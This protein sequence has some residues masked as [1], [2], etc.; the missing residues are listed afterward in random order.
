[1]KYLRNGAY[2][3]LKK[4]GR[5][6]ALLKRIFGKK[7]NRMDA[8]FADEQTHHAETCICNDD[9]RTTVKNPAH[10]ETGEVN[11]YCSKKCNQITE[12]AEGTPNHSHEIE[13]DQAVEATC[14]E[15]GMTAGSHCKRCGAIIEA[16]K[17]IPALGHE[18]EADQAVEA[19]CTDTGLTAG[20]RCKRCGAI[21]EVQKEIPVLGHEIEADQ[22]VE[23]TCTEAGMTAGSHCKRCGAVIEARKEI[24]AL[25]HEIEIDNAVEATCTE[26]GLTAGSHCARCGKILE[27]QQVVMRTATSTVN[28]RIDEIENCDGASWPA[29]RLLAFVGTM[30]KYNDI[31]ES[32]CLNGIVKFGDILDAYRKQERYTWIETI[33]ESDWKQA[34]LLCKDIAKVRSVQKTGLTVAMHRSNGARD[35][36]ISQIM[37]LSA[38]EMSAEY[39]R[40]VNSVYGIFHDHQDAL[41]F[42][43]PSGVYN[44]E[45][46][47]EFFGRIAYRRICY[48]CD[49][50]KIHSF[51]EEQ[52]SKPVGLRATLKSEASN[53]R[54]RILNDW[55]H[56]HKY[57]IEQYNTQPILGSIELDDT[58]YGL[59]I[60]YLQKKFDSVAYGEQTLSTN[61]AVCVAL[62]QIA[63]RC[64]GAAYWPEVSKA[65]GR[66]INPTMMGILGKCFLN[67]MKENRKA[68]FSSSEYVAS[69]KLHTFVNNANIGRLFDFLY[70]YYEL[71]LGRNI[72]FADI[73]ALCKLM[74]SG[75]YFSRQQN[76]MQS[77]LDAILLIPEASENR[78]RMYLSWIDEAFWNRGWLPEGNDR[79]VKGF[80]VW[81]AKHP[82]FN[83]TW[84]KQNRTHKFGKRMF[85]HPT[86]QLNLA[87]GKI[88]VVLPEQLLPFDSGD[89]AEWI[90]DSRKNGCV[91]SSLTES[92][93]GCRTEELFFALDGASLFDE[94][95][96]N[97]ICNE[98]TVHN[99]CIRED[100]VRFFNA[101]GDMLTGKSI[102]EGQYFVLTKPGECIELEKQYKVQHY[103]YY[104]F[105]ACEL[106]D[107]DTVVLPDGT[108]VLVGREISEGLFGNSKSEGAYVENCND[109]N[110]YRIPIYSSC[111][112]YLLKATE[113]EYSKTRIQLNGKYF[114]A[115]DIKYKKIKLNDRS[116]DTGYIM[117]LPNSSN[118]FE[119]YR[120]DI[121]IPGTNATHQG[122]FCYWSGFGFRFDNG[123][124]GLPYW[125]TSKGSICFERYVAIDDTGL[126]KNPDSYNEYG[127]EIDPGQKCLS[128][129]IMGTDYH[130][131]LDIPDCVWKTGEEELWHNQ[132]LG[133]LWRH[134][135]PD[136]VL[137][138]TD[139]TEMYLFVDRDGMKNGQCVRYTRNKDQESIVC[140]LLPIKQ[141]LTR[142]K[143]KHDVCI[144]VEGKVFDFAAVYCKSYLLSCHLEADYDTGSIRGKFDIMGDRE[145]C[146]SVF[147][148]DVEVLSQV[149]LQ[150]G[151]FCEQTE[152]ETDTY[153]AVVYEVINDD[154]GFET[155]YDEIARESIRLVNPKDL[156]GTSLVLKSVDTVNHEAV[157]LDLYDKL[158]H[159]ELLQQEKNAGN[160][161]YGTMKKIVKGKVIG[162]ME[163][164]VTFPD[165]GKINHCAVMF[166]DKNENEWL[167][168]MYD[169]GQNFIV[170]REANGLP[171]MER[172]RRYA[173]MLPEDTFTAVFE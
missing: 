99:Y 106:K 5:F 114:R 129:P 101:S 70:A 128:L 154:F 84:E 89:K 115:T 11:G 52:K 134:E 46:A 133:E 86:L 123:E 140:D 144:S 69:I 136:K 152:M 58:E 10:E 29:G 97:L 82:D 168:F 33:N 160:T 25:G 107:G 74:T 42:L 111:P 62:V 126:I 59:L 102:P 23:A 143:V 73:P 130:L 157:R 122:Q 91:V 26:T 18:I 145:Y 78:L 43:Y 35:E 41:S 112:I 158:Y 164:M 120:F 14:T 171:Y 32:L 167:P 38:Y 68:T 132:P 135:L 51:H 40:Y 138:R 137:F 173:L 63:N 139:S 80:T 66:A 54:T 148:N 113:D 71:D 109:K 39:T 147:R 56:L 27:I 121:S 131:V 79:F 118:E 156:I 55:E 119:V 36:K 49:F 104:N 44:A 34:M 117:Y 127:F 151:E 108:L 2:I 172:Y 6:S 165:I 153:T 7:P 77:T 53:R 163:V 61:K 169:R 47:E 100:C 16:Q 90:I 149:P 67:T 105:V 64:P 159:I 57:I 83:G 75:T 31:K 28:I 45:I 162:M 142:D 124:F 110:A 76:I 19:T 3:M 155:Q 85:S 92:V 37:S 88:C 98:K 12:R 48:A 8:V 87:D 116:D 60:N 146:V 150:N 21:I 141:W 94:V 20:S 15:V 30:D 9:E 81:T 96:I 50:K 161:Y 170:K 103:E 95:K 17:E 93:T 22:A 1:M 72:H 125:N 65:I 13:A 166:F 24:P 4:L